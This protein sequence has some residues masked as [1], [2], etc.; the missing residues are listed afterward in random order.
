MCPGSIAARRTDAGP[1]APPAEFRGVD[2]PEGMT[3][4]LAA[5][6]EEMIL[7]YADSESDYSGVFPLEFGVM[8]F[9]EIQRTL[10]P[11]EASGAEPT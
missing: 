5:R 1:G 3:P 2:L 6:L 9:E 7:A 4:R 8:L 11:I 10:E